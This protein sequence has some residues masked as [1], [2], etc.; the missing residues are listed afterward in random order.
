MNGKIVS[1]TQERSCHAQLPND[2]LIVFP[3]PI[4][5]TLKL[6]DELCFDELVFDIDVS[7]WNLSQDTDFKVF[8][9]A[10]NIHDLRIAPKHGESR[11]PTR[12]RLYGS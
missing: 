12:N 2:I 7:V 6:G 9:A 10:S 4:G 5:H 11:T 1:I 8:V 3:E